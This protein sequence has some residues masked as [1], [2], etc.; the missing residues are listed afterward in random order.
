[1]KRF[2]GTPRL[3]EL[4]LLNGSPTVTGR[5]HVRLGPLR[6]EPLPCLGVEL[7][8]T[9]QLV[10]HLIYKAVHALRVPPQFA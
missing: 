1:M 2:A 5:R 4:E 7:E 8:Q 6:T 9:P 3:S 10:H